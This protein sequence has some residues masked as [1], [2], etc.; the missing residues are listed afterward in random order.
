MIRE[1]VVLAVLFALAEPS[2]FSQS[3]SIDE[4]ILTGYVTR[5]NTPSDFDVDGW[6]IRSDDKTTFYQSR[7]T[8]SI[9]NR[10]SGG[11]VYLGERVSLFG[12][13]D[14]KKHR[15]EAREVT[16]LRTDDDALS[17]LA[18]VDHLFPLDIGG[19]LV[20]RADGYVIKL[21]QSTILDSASMVK[22]E[23]LKVGDWIGYNG[24]LRQNGVLVA[25][26]VAFYPSQVSDREAWLR[27]K[28]DY[29]PSA[30]PDDAKQTTWAK[31]WNITDPK[32]IPPYHDEALQT[33]I[34]RIGKQLIP[35]YQRALGESDPR[36]VHFQFQLVSG[37]KWKDSMSL[38]SG[39]I[40][41]PYEI[42][43][44]LADDSQLAAVLADNMAAVLEK[45]SYRLLP[46][47]TTLSAVNGASLVGAFFVPGLGLG[48]GATALASHKI[49]TDL[50]NQ[51]GR[52]SLC[53]MHDSG[54]D[55]TQAPIAWRTLYSKN[56]NSAIPSRAINLYRTIGL[57]WHNYPESSGNIKMPIQNRNQVQN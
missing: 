16:F 23:D 10:E 43:E 31:V 14:F 11:E 51:S 42:V 22:Q 50:L 15:I 46:A 32:H 56:S 41:I 55:V 37:K 9:M 54:Y 24:V 45:Q 28:T 18:I 44:R 7:G 35:T 4:P 21:D 27:S 19:F 33:R 25:N 2:S 12:K 1:F 13:K 36:K 39:I 17:G 49:S 29:D 40:L 8:S 48:S 38:P 30:V 5:G 6:T 34:D 47:S 3:S 53:L 57:V 20:L 26:K 52:V